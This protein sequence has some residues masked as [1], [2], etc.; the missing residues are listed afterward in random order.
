MGTPIDAIRHFKFNEERVGDNSNLP[1][2]AKKCKL[3]YA[4]VVNA[5]TAVEKQ[6]KIIAGE[7]LPTD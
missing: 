2:K 1:V 6:N 7:N 3:M 5:S 4:E